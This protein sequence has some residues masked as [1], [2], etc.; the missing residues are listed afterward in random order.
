MIKPENITKNINRHC[1]QIWTYI[2]EGIDVCP[3]IIYPNKPKDSKLLIL[4]EESF[5]RNGVSIVWDSESIL[6]T[7]Q[8]NLTTAST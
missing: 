1:K 8:R 2:E 7:R 5:Q 3:G 6:E 4:I